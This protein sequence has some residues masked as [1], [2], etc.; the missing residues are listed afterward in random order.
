V[1]ELMDSGLEKSVALVEIDVHEQSDKNGQLD[2]C[3]T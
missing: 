3:R 2:T 1:I